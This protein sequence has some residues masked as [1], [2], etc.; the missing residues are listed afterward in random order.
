MQKTQLSLTICHANTHTFTDIESDLIFYFHVVRGIVI[1]MWI[2]SAFF[3]PIHLSEI[4]YGSN[5]ATDILEN[6]FEI[7][8]AEALAVCLVRRRGA[9]D[10]CLQSSKTQYNCHHT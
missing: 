8:S 2:C 9:E 3:L 1:D 7:I 5:L 4:M 10:N 6:L